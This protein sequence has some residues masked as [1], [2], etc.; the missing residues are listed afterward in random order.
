MVSFLYVNIFS[1]S[2]VV[3]SGYNIATI[4]IN[5]ISSATK[6][7]ALKTFIRTMDLDV[8]FLQEVYHTDLALPGYNVLSN[9]DASRRGTTIAL[10]DHLKFSH[11]ERSLDSRL[12]CIRLE[13]IATLCNVY[14]PSGSQRRAEREEF[15]NRTVAFYLRNAC[16]HVIFAGDFNC[17]LKSKDVTGGGNF[18]LAQQKAVNSMGMSDSWEAL[19]G[20]SVEF[21]YI[22][23]GSGSR[24]DRCYVSSSLVTQLRTTDMHVL[25]F[26][27]HKALTVRL[28]LPTPAN[29]LTYN[30]YWQLR[31]HVLRVRCRE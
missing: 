14:A 12:I 13:N 2:S 26:S 31:P 23:S 5:T 17:V 24:I 29:R 25:S 28:C 6:L 3:S 15:F 30:G 20:N 7:E 19:R 10:R 27:D 11:V 1:L 9:V 16:P 18:S 22:T 21:S 4:N 8:T